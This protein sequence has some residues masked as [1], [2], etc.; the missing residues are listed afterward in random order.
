MGIF[1]NQ[2]KMRKCLIFILALAI[3]AQA[4]TNEGKGLKAA[5]DIPDA[6]LQV[7]DLESTDDPKLEEIKVAAEE[8]V[9]S[10]VKPKV[11]AVKIEVAEQDKPE[12]KIDAD[13][14]KTEVENTNNDKPAT[15]SEDKSE[16]KSEKPAKI[17]KEVVT[18]K[19]A[20]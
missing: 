8:I 14:L 17:V 10:E 9:V 13:M 20:D 19:K 3:V 5:E 2:T 11:K 1:L 16:K 7:D 12:K 18:E 15:K 6:K 4:L